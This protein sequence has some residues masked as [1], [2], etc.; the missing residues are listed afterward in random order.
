MAHNDWVRDVAW[1]PSTGLDRFIKMNNH[2]L[3]LEL[4]F[5]IYNSY[6]RQIIASCDHD[7]EARVWIKNPN[8]FEWDSKLLKKFDFPLWHVSWRLVPQFR[9]PTAKLKIPGNAFLKSESRT[10]VTFKLQ[11]LTLSIYHW[12]LLGLSKSATMK[13]L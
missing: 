11:F 5:R 10:S 8:S 13:K 1:A 4:F 9:I 7:G 2:K 12:Q 3:C 6:F